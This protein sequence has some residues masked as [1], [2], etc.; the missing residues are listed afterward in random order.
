MNRLIRMILSAALGLVA[1]NAAGDV[2]PR[3]GDNAVRSALPSDPGDFLISAGERTFPAVADLNLVS[4]DPDTRRFAVA[5]LQ[6]TENS[7]LDAFET[8]Q[9]AIVDSQGDPIA[10]PSPVARYRP[11]A[12][13]VSNPAIAVDG[14]GYFTVSWSVVELD[15]SGL[16]RDIEQRI[17]ARTFRPERNGGTLCP[18]DNHPVLYDGLESI[19]LDTAN[20]PP[21]TDDFGDFDITGPRPSLDIDSSDEGATV[22]TFADPRFAENWGIY[23]APNELIVDDPLPDET[24]WCGVGGGHARLVPTGL[25]WQVAQNAEFQVAPRV[26]VDANNE[27]SVVVWRSFDGAILAKRLDADGRPVP[28]DPIEVAAEPESTQESVHD[29]DVDYTPDG[30][31]W[32]TWER[33]QYLDGTDDAEAVSEILASRFDSSGVP[34]ESDVVVDLDTTTF[35]QMFPLRNARVQARDLSGDLAFSYSRHREVCPIAGL[36]GAPILDVSSSS[37]CVLESILGRPVRIVASSGSPCTFSLDR[38]SNYCRM[39]V[40]RRPYE[41]AVSDAGSFRF[42]PKGPTSWAVT[43]TSTTTFTLNPFPP[44]SSENQCS[45]LELSYPGGTVDVVVERLCS[46]SNPDD[47]ITCLE[48]ANPAAARSP[49]ANLLEEGAGVIVADSSTQRRGDAGFADTDIRLQWLQKDFQSEDATPIDPILV[50]DLPLTAGE[51]ALAMGRS[52]D[53]MVAWIAE[54]VP[55]AG[56]PGTLSH[57]LITQNLA[58]P[59]ELSIN[60]VGI[61]EGPILRATGNFTLTANK[62]Y[63]VRDGECDGD[64]PRPTVSLLTADGS[65]SFLPGADDY[66]RTTDTLSFDPCDPLAPL[67]L[68][69]PV[70]VN[71]DNVFEDTESFFVDLFD[72]QNAIVVRRRGTGAIVD[73]DPPATVSA[74]S[75]IVEVCEDGTRPL[76]DPPPDAPRCPGTGSPRNDVE[77]AF[78]L[79]IAQEVEGSVEFVTMDG[80]AFGS[81]EVATANDDYEPVAGELQFLPGTT[82]AFLSI[83]LIADGFAELPEQFVVQLTGADNLT[84]PADDEDLKIL[85]NIIDDD[86]CATPPAWFLPDPDAV[87]PDPLPTHGTAAERSGYF[88]VVNPEGF[89]TCPWTARLDLDQG[90]EPWLERTNIVFSIPPDPQDPDGVTADDIAAAESACA[91]IA[92]ATGAIRYTAEENLPDLV[93][94]Q[95]RTQD[96][97]FINGAAEPEARTV[98]QSGGDCTPQITPMQARFFPVGGEATFE[99]S[100][101]DEPACEISEWTAEVDSTAADWLSIDGASAD[102]GR[103]TFSG[104]GAFSIE[105][106]PYL[107]DTGPVADRVGVINV[108]DSV[109]VIQEAPLFD[110]FDDEVPPDP[111]GWQYQ[112]PDSWSEAGT[113]LSAST[114][115]FARL[116]ANP[117]FPGCSRCIVETTVRFD[118]FSKGQAIVYL[119]WRGEGEHLRLVADEFFD[120][121]TLIQRVGGVDHELRVFGS[122]VQVG[123]EYPV[124]IEYRDD[125]GGPLITVDVD[126]QAMCP[127]P[128]SGGEP[129]TPWD[130]DDDAVPP[131]IGSGTVG[132]GVSGTGASFNLLRV[133]R[134]DELTLPLDGLFI[135]GFE[136]AE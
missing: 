104:P 81:I 54:D 30:F 100:F 1:F 124:R 121:W 88:C 87:T 115:G 10:G 7:S 52:G 19:V 21:I 24:E 59:V 101:G 64:T 118:E 117:A 135:D 71:D 3:L 93:P 119:W 83:E 23:A 91:L 49:R 32:V 56:G 51:P 114:P 28:G 70:P 105:V 35:G 63:P 133:I 38:R 6:R 116:I 5:W 33:N 122:D 16:G 129:C 112:E 12:L 48:Q 68:G 86:V 40:K 127:A 125:L 79:D 92:G 107:P 99:V 65:A 80:D 77:L 110:H 29:P 20:W 53:M 78:E 26:A 22:I 131:V 25:L 42:D 9:V 4:D 128:G 74:P 46:R 102:T 31:F 41:G 62:P 85:V 90:E 13:R 136:P 130:P 34:V 69:F 55:E 2:I 43:P 108:G 132:F 97:L 120:S 11:G 18:S 58:G 45:W 14:N 111:A 109:E 36:D 98:T 76:A 126:G 37:S 57:S 72:E 39:Q 89:E 123:Q 113:H 134:S 44:R 8:I 75:G 95:T 84:L 61:L 47:C 73:N 94:V 15:T 106:E 66:S 60:D 17:H 67:S 50:N 96:V 103:F 27:R 82:Q